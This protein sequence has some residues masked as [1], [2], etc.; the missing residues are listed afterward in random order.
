M[1]DTVED[2]VVV[3]DNREVLVSQKKLPLKEISGSLSL[4]NMSI[5]HVQSFPRKW[6]MTFSSIRYI[7]TKYIA[8][9]MKYSHTFVCKWSLKFL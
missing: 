3:H 7:F 2:E 5:N 9:I 4:S 8:S 6:K 1:L